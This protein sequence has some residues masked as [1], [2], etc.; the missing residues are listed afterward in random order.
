MVKG[1]ENGKKEEL[2][3]AIEAYRAEKR[4]RSSF[5]ADTK[6]LQPISQILR[7]AYDWMDSMPFEGWLWEI[8]RRSP[9]YIRLCDELDAWLPS[10]EAPGV[11]SAAQNLIWDIEDLGINVMDRSMVEYHKGKVIVIWDTLGVS[12]DVVWIRG[13]PLPEFDYREF[14]HVHRL[15]NLRSFVVHPHETFRQWKSTPS[16]AI[17]SLTIGTLE[18]TIFVGI[19]RYAKKADLHNLCKELEEHLVPRNSR[20]R[21][22]AWKVYIVAYDLREQKCEFRLI[23]EL[24]RLAYRKTQGSCTEHDVK[25]FFK[26]AV[27]L[28][29]KDKYREF[30]PY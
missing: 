8:I 25:I 10:K 4:R 27:E 12:S 29:E 13:I 6:D 7:E 17:S 19:S 26:N 30:L 20:K 3:Q 22:D 21:P 15:V 23:A 5:F 1:E 18:N 28:I 14:S 9:E 2:L 11:S 24:L 16:S